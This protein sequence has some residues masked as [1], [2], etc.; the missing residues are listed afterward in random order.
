MKK[1]KI[2]NNPEKKIELN[3]CPD[4]IG[5]GMR[6]KKKKTRHTHLEIVRLRN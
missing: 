4:K 6:K 1:K 2:D 3:R 5:T